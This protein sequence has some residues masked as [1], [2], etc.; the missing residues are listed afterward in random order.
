MGVVFEEIFK[1]LNHPMFW[2]FVFASATGYI[3]V[4]AAPTIIFGALYIVFYIL[5]RITY[6]LL[7]SAIF[8]WE[9]IK[10]ALGK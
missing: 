9:V 8:I 1:M 6:W 4:K 2:T 5:G 10:K 7:F 3:I